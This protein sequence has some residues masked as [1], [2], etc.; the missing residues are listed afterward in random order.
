[1]HDLQT[2]SVHGH[3][4]DL[5]ASM[6]LKN[7]DLPSM[8]APTPPPSPSSDG[9]APSYKGRVQTHARSVSAFGDLLLHRAS[10]LQVS[11]VICVVFR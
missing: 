9:S 11:C 8:D 4:A 5:F 1:M 3:I 10:L 2:C 7:I 6:A